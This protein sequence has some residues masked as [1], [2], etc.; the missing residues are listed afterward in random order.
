[1]A[2]VP[3]GIQW[4]ILRRWIVF[5]AAAALTACGGSGMSSYV[6]GAAGGSSSS[7]GT[8]GGGGYGSNP[9]PMNPPPMQ[10][11]PPQAS[12][13][14]QSVLVS[15]GAVAAA[16]KD[17][18]LKNP[19]G[20][21]FAPNAPVWVANNATQTSTLYDGTGTIQPLVVALPSGANGPADAT[22]IVFN[23]S[24]DFVIGSGSASGPALF[25]YAGESGTISGWAPTVD[26]KNAALAYDDG[27]GGAIYKGLAIAADANGAN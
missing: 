4:R 11:P 12:A 22:G 5:A 16:S 17:P 9:P 27:A 25:I 13:Y 2:S 8:G 15:D 21:V 10:N 14:S 24:A 7:S 3:A 18:N 20:I 26:A 23:G 6:G 1:M 19:W